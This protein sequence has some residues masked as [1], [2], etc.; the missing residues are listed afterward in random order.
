MAGKF[1]GKVAV[2]TGGNSGIGLASARYFVSEGATVFVTGRRQAQLDQAV[3]EMGSSA[4]GVQGDVTVQ[5]DMERLYRTVEEQTGAVDIVVANA[6]EAF[7]ARIGDY[8]DEVIDKNFDLNL[9]GTIYT[10]QKALPLMRRGGAVVLM[11]SIEAL[12]GSENLGLYAAS[13]AALRSFARTWST[14]LKE[15]GI[16]VNVMS[17]GIVFTPAYATAGVSL[18]DLD[19]VIPHIPVGRLGTV[20]D[21]A[22][23]IGFLASEDSAFMTAAELVV[24]GGQTQV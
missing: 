14:E 9:K 1:E 21:I 3:T 16:R 6:G 17:P 4:I 24:D 2:V 23:A 7:F 10:V 15:R 11:G 8:T 5:A 18:R 12:R 13:K 19:A 20:E 22:R